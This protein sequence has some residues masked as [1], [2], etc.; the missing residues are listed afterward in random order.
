V[1]DES[2]WES[3]VSTRTSDAVLRMLRRLPGTWSLARKARKAARSLPT[4]KDEVEVPDSDEIYSWIEGIC[5]T[6]HRRPG[7]PEGHSAERWVAERFR[8]FGLEDVSMDP[9]PIT[10]WSASKWSLRVGDDTVPSFY[11]PY[12]EFTGPD[13][14]TGRLIYAGKG[15]RGTIEKMD[16]RGRIVVAEVTFPVF[17]TGMLLKGLRSSYYVSDPDGNISIK[18]RQYMNFVRQNFMGGA[19]DAAHAPDNDVY[20]RACAGGGAGVCLILRDQPAGTST[21]YGP[22]DGIMKPMPGLWIGK[23]EAPGLI[24]SARQEETATLTLEGKAE[25][26]TMH[27]VWGVLPGMSDD[28]ILVT[29][30]HDSPFTGAIED[31]AGVAQVL[32]QARA[33]SRVPRKKRPM[34]IIFVVDAG[35][36]YGSEGGRA[37]ARQ[38]PDIMRRTRLLVTLEHLGGKEVEESGRHYA[39][40]GRLALTVM[41]TTPDPEVVALTIHALKTKPA[42]VTAVIPSDLLAP[43]PTS[44]AL[45]YLTEVDVPVVSWIGCPYYLL[46]DQDTLDKVDRKELHPIAETVTEL[47]RSRMTAG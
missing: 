38:H 44:D 26:G 31:G 35:H 36:F 21:H 17:P 43:V 10:S 20:W 8:E 47:I 1:E 2:S 42:K 34:T 39:E 9:V 29:S 22:Y 40:T 7:T 32:A 5:V 4:F 14:V 45:G 28:V 27:N 6:P 37:F 46:D 33:W 15:G 25:P 13:G 18:S 19:A 23:H 30:H 41:F 24:E 16:V 12:T 3:G 11:I